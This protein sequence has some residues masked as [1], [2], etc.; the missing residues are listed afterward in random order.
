MNR[1]TIACALILTLS[2]AN[3][4]A[5]AD[6]CRLAYQMQ[7]GQV[8]VATVVSQNK[9]SAMG[10]ES[11]QT[12]RFSIRYRVLKGDRPGWV[13]LQAKIIKHSAQRQGGIDY[14]KLTFSADMHR[15]GELRNMRH[16]GSAMPPIP[17]EQLRSM[18]PQYAEMMRQSGET[19]A[20]AMQQAVF[21][22][23][24]LP[25][26]RL[27]IGD[28]FDDVQHS[29]LGSNAMMKA[30]TVVKTEYTL[31]DVSQGLA[32]FAVRQRAQSKTSGMGGSSDTKTAGKADAIFDLEQ[33]MWAEMTTKSRSTSSFAG[34][35]GMSGDVSSLQ[36]SRYRMQLQ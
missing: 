31:E 30:Q 16:T 24:E 29:D 17:E 9:S 8:W 22:F 10:Q 20:R 25:E 19:V 4:A 11:T 36:V 5:A 23:P 12:N 6:S 21:W 28:S 35:G 15:T 1:L 2:G 26:E 7:P 32:Y 33:G 14:S 34:M 3:V 13:R 18:P 27:T